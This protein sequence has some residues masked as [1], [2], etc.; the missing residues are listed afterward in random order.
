MFHYLFVLT[1]AI[2]VGTEHPVEFR[3]RDADERLAVRLAKG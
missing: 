1:E 2:A 3:L